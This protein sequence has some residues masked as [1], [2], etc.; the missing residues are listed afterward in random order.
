MRCV[1]SWMTMLAAVGLVAVAVMAADAE[2]AAPAEKAPAAKPAE[3][4]PEEGFVAIFNG[5]DLTDWNGDN[6]HWS[7]KDGAIH[8]ECTEQTK[9]TGGNTF[10]IWKGGKPADFE[11]RLSAK[12]V[13]GNSGIQY[14]SFTPVT[15]PEKYFAGGYQMEISTDPK[16][17]GFIYGELWRGV[18]M[19]GVGEKCV[20]N[21]GKKVVGA[22]GDKAEI[23][24]HFKVG[25]WNDYRIVA[26]GN[27]IDQYLN[28]IHVVD[29]TDEDPKALT[30]GVI[31]L[32]IH[33]GY[34]MTIDFKDI[35]LKILDKEA[36][37][38]EEKKPDAPKAEAP[39]ADKK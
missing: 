19:C 8:G 23:A 27:H 10:L 36:A 11:L 17:A 14:R 21:G 1:M 16:N 25:D 39:K 34:V 4:I 28:G 12:M 33:Q 2:K 15:N 37:K 26:K 32:Q 7:V 24:S 3:K 6:V 22:L 5:K 31:G 20:W 30:S 29:F 13:G 9:V 38:P 35:R 18:S